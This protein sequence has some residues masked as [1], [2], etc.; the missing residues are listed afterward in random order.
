MHPGMPL[1]TPQPI[2]R[3]AIKVETFEHT[4]VSIG[5]SATLQTLLGVC[6]R[7]MSGAVTVVNCAGLSSGGDLVPTC[8]VVDTVDTLLMAF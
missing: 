6:G 4:L 7:H 3:T 5:I 1:S 8:E 2:P